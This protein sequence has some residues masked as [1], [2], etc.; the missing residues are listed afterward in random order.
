MKKEKAAADPLYRVDAI[1]LEA[2]YWCQELEADHRSTFLD[3]TLRSSPLCWQSSTATA[4]RSSTCSARKA[5]RDADG[6]TSRRG[7]SLACRPVCRPR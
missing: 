5:H 1:P 7:C 3:V 2:P 4:A 6:L